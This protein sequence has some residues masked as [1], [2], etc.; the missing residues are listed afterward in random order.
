MTRKK[1]KA[2]YALAMLV[3]LGCGLIMGIIAM[4]EQS[5]RHDLSSIESQGHT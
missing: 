4:N 3:P 2:L 1:K 5:R